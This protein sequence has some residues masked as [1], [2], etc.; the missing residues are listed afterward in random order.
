MQ[1]WTVQSGLACRKMTLNLRFPYA[2]QPGSAETVKTRLKL[3]IR[4]VQVP[5]NAYNGI[6]EVDRAG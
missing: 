3:E 1:R 6:L 4:F 5:I 2:F